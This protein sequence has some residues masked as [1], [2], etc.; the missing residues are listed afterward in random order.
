[1]VTDRYPL[2]GSPG[3]DPPREIIEPGVTTERGRHWPVMTGYLSSRCHLAIPGCE[4]RA[5]NCACHF[6]V[7]P[8]IQ[9]AGPTV[10]P[11]SGL[12]KPGPGRA[13]TCGHRW[14]LKFEDVTRQCACELLAGHQPARRHRDGPFVHDV[15]A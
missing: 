10:A 2:P 9:D 8:V 11:R 5:C 4:D 13:Q 12:E 3:G 6:P 15:V 14:V 7:L 1:M